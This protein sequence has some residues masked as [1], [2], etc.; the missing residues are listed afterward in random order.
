MPPLAS[1]VVA[2]A[3]VACLP[4]NLGVLSSILGYDHSDLA[5]TLFAYLAGYTELQNLYNL[6][7]S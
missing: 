5:R 6:S 4:P 7:R 2:A 1:K 3:L